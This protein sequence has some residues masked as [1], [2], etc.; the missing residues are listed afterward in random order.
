MAAS[1]GRPFGHAISPTSTSGPP[2]RDEEE[3]PRK[4]NAPASVELRLRRP[5]ALGT[6]AAGEL[7]PEHAH[8]HR[9][10][11]W[12]PLRRRDRA[13]PLGDRRA[14]LRPDHARDAGAA[15][16]DEP[17]EHRAGQL[18]AGRAGPRQVP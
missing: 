15:L 5:R 10:L 13:R 16:R 9:A 14:A 2:P 18:P 3:P 7:R 12:L 6:L 11:P 1:R 8:A 17:L 4:P